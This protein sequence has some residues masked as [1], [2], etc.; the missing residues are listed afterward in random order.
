MLCHDVK[1]FSNRFRNY[2][3]PGHISVSK[4]CPHGVFLLGRR[5]GFDREAEKAGWHA[6]RFIFSL[7][8]DPQSV[9][10]DIVI[11]VT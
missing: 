1:E 10:C 2:G 9:L 4:A 5:I 8:T 7:S 6:K 3:L 11:I